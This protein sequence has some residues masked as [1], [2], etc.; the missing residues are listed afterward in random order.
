MTAHRVDEFVAAI[1]QPDAPA[2]FRD[3]LAAYA[4][5]GLLPEVAVTVTHTDHVRLNLS[6]A[7][8]HGLAVIPFGGG[9]HSGLGNVPTAYDIALSTV[10][11]DRIIAH[12]PADMT[13]T[14]EAGVPLATLQAVLAH[15]GQ[16]LPL[17]P[18][19]GGG[20]TVG[21]VLA[22]NAQGAL[23]HAFGTARD[24]LIGVKVVQ[25]DGTLVKSGGR[26]VKNVAGYDMGKLYVG[27]LGSL[28]VIVEATFKLAPLPAAVAAIGVTCPSPHA[29]AMLL[30]AA[31]DAGLALHAAE[32][33]SPAAGRAVLGDA[34]W[35]ALVRVAGR[36]RAVERT[37]RELREIAGGLRA[38]YDLRDPAQTARAWDD[39]FAPGALSLRVSVLPRSVAGAIEEMEAALGG[40]AA[41]LSSTLGA[42]LIRARVRPESDAEAGMLVGAV[43]DI[44]QRHDGALV[45]EAAAPAVKRA[46]DVFGPARPDFA[47]M[48]RLKQALDPSRTLA[49]GRF[50]GGL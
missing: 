1:S 16:F 20:A 33:L 34:R 19:G 24:W 9:T 18:P 22:A 27:S 38:T 50:A 25:A 45:V 3:G 11:L 2:V 43:R 5:D 48:R 14:V 28:G 36:A 10:G 31:H 8:K 39:A 32:L 29:A 15:H 30:F 42:G 26:V 12:E 40:A 47:I 7:Q 37:L 49:P 13:V 35:S 46:I 44:A 21:G 41:L 6:E 4:V 17:D 23:R